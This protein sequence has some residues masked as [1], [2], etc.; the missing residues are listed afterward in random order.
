ML[1]NLSSGDRHGQT[2]MIRTGKTVKAYQWSSTAAEWQLIGDVMDAAEPAPSAAGPKVTYQGQVCCYLIVFRLSCPGCI[3]A[4]RSRTDFGL[5]GPGPG[6]LRCRPGPVKFASWFGPCLDPAPCT[7]PYLFI[8][9]IRLR[10][11]RGR[12][13]RTATPEVALQP[14][15][16][17]T[18]GCRAVPHAEQPARRLPGTGGRVHR[19]E[20]GCG[21][22][23]GAGRG[24][25]ICR[26][27]YGWQSVGFFVDLAR[28]IF[29][30]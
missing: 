22:H 17:P 4:F 16:G 11:R 14:W 15:H 21:R 20:C 29:G 19:Q 10:Y 7:Y 28:F 12:G 18:R 3:S 5:S 25:R 6:R 13:G 30:T 26:S 2:K 9:G 1:R 8:S 27:I 23:D 24:K